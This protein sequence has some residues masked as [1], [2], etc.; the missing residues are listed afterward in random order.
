MTENKGPIR[1][2]LVDDHQLVRS[3]LGTY[4]EVEADLQL[5]GEAENGRQAAAVF[6]QCRPDVVLMDLKMPGMD[7]VETTQMLLERSPDAKILILTSFE[8]EKLVHAALEAGAIG[9]LLKDISP[10]GLSEAIRTAYRGDPALSP[11][12]ARALVKATR[13]EKDPAAE[14]TPRELD[15]LQLLVEGVSNPEIAARLFISPSTVK[16]HVS[17]VLSKLG[18]TSRTEAAAYAIRHQLVE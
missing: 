15:V 9:Y 18:V 5:V 3:G 13:K 12:A 4:L 14:L 7:G 2:M 6:D 8:E 11:A 1:V 10:E 17:S 16:T